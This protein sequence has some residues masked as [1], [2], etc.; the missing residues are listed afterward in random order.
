M[1][2][3]LKIENDASLIEVEVD[4]ESLFRKLEII[5]SKI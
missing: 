4:V 1:L 3:F 2:I 5:F